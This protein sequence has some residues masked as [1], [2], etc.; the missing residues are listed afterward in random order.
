MS[1]V[2]S[3]AWPASYKMQKMR[4]SIFTLSKNHL[5]AAKKAETFGFVLNLLI[6]NYKI[7][8]SSWVFILTKFHNQN[9]DE[10]TYLPIILM[11][12]KPYMREHGKIKVK[13][14]VFP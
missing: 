2:I 7:T 6:E 9:L 12:G 1:I 13:I 11:L 14:S 3:S 5:K 4:N 8:I 10:T